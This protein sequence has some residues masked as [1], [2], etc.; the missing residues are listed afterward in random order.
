MK[1][2]PLVNGRTYSWSDVTVNVLGNPVAGITEVTYE[3]KQDMENVYGAGDRP[4][5]RGYGKVEASGSISLLVDEV[6]ALMAEAPNGRL[7]DIPEF[8]V[9]VAY[10]TESGDVITHTI[11]NCKFKANSRSFKTGDMKMEVKMELLV[12]HIEWQ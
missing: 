1:F 5:A 12:S 2:T 8:D 11:K 4:V 7:T 6:E 9:V 10:E 3:E